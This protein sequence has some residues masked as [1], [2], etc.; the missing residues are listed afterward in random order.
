MLSF[1]NKIYLAEGFCGAMY[2]N[3]VVNKEVSSN[4]CEFLTLVT[5]TSKRLKHLTP[6]I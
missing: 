2:F 1:L 6:K 5:N 3:R 4:F